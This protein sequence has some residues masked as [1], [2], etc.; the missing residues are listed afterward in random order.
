VDDATAWVTNRVTIGSHDAG[1]LVDGYR[2]SARAISLPMTKYI[3]AAS[4]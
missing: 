1:Q 2:R 3:S 4:P